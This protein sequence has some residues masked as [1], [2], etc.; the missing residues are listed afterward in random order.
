MNLQA[1]TFNPFQ[2]NTYVIWDDSL[3]CV[4]IDPGCYST[5]EKFELQQFIQNNRLNPVALWLTHAHLDHVFGVNFVHQTW[6][7]LPQLHPMEETIYDNAGAVGMMYGV[8]V[9]PLPNGHRVL[10]E[11]DTISIGS[12]IFEVRFTPGHSPGSVCF[13]DHVS[14]T[15]I[16]G[17]VLFS[18]SI[19]R[20]DLPG[21]H[22]QTLIDSIERELLSLEDDYIVYSGHGPETTIGR[23]RLGNP[24][25]R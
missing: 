1:F 8:P 24:F 16:A 18:G 23:E 12:L 20:T 3:N 22:Y 25:L 15:V 6:H 7:L 13:I 5:A 2:E 9:E 19:G 11:D 4:I 14:K 21:G 10:S 17:D